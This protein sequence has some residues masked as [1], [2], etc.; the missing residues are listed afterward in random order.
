MIMQTM[1]KFVCIYIEPANIISKHLKLNA[2]Q[3]K[4]LNGGS[5]W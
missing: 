1:Q 5:T 4:S 2:I 3:V